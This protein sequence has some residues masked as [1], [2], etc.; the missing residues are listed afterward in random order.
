MDYLVIMRMGDI[1]DPEIQRKRAELRD[2]H[3]ARAATFR[4]RG[5]VIIGGAVLDEH[6][7]PAGSAAIARFDSRAEVDAW[8]Q[9]DPWTKAGVWKDFEVI[10]FKISENYPQGRG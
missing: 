8:L 4:D 10:P 2:A 9:D 7:T 3:L 1:N 5:H 6:G